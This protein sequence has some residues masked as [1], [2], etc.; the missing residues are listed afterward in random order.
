[1]KS[2]GSVEFMLIMGEWQGMVTALVLDMDADFDV[3]LGMEWFLK[4]EPD[5][6]AIA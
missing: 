4:W 3:V 1:M 2:Y 6:T 5:W